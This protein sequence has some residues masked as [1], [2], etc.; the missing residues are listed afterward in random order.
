MGLSWTLYM[1]KEKDFGGKKRKGKREGGACSFY[2]LFG[3]K[4]KIS[5]KIKSDGR[6]VENLEKSEG[7]GNFH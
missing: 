6:K 2:V 7:C 1:L 5:V 4:R 3:R